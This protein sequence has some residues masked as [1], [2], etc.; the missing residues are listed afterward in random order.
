MADL[1][2]KKN[3]T[4]YSTR[5]RRG[6]F[7]ALLSILMIAVVIAINLVAG[8]LPTTYTKFDISKAKYYT[9]SEQTKEMIKSLEDE[10]TIYLLAE[11]GNEDE[12]TL[13]LVKRFD[14][15]SDKISLEVIDTV[16][17]PNFSKQYTEDILDA[18]SLIVAGPKSNKI[19]EYG[20]MYVLD[21]GLYYFNGTYEYDFDGEGQIVSA[22][23][24]VI[25]KD[26]SKV[27]NLAGHGEAELSFPLQNSL[28]KQNLEVVPL[29]L[30]TGTTIPEDA[31][32]LMMI[33]PATDLNDEEAEGILA[34]LENGG[35]LLLVTD[36]AEDV[37][38]NLNRIMEYAGLRFVDGIVF[39]GNSNYCIKDHNNYLL[40]EIQ[41]HDITKSLINHNY[42]IV[43]PNAQAVEEI[44]P[45]RSTLEITP[46]LVSS[47]A[48]Y[49]KIAGYNLTTRDKEKEDIDG[50]FTLGVL[51][52]EEYNQTESSFIWFGT[53]MLLDENIDKTVGGANSD[54]L[55][56]S[57]ATLCNQKSN[58]SIH[59][60]SMKDDKIV[61]SAA[62]SILWSVVLII[63]L[64]L[65]IL[66]TGFTV[67][68]RR[69]K[70]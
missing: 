18:N 1:K 21:Y 38:P 49:S 50:P 55:I 69:R 33:S 41:F 58:T 36:Y 37:R 70:R 44:N 31:G 61:L 64:P 66:M 11:G 56:H 40:P 30:I 46:L 45:H 48:A 62:Q 43:L 9:F 65:A 47:D 24:Y 7:S 59:L 13:E 15:L 32:C 27:Y 26:G 60:K 2:W 10:V 52:T 51:V 68:F 6:G 35:K 25:N 34:Y 19:V 5:L 57:L 3:I 53:G 20:D 4:F 67:W 12:M 23:D 29:N 8:A 39:E 42:S 16:V 54:L 17:Y 22:I 63:V 28:K 14:M